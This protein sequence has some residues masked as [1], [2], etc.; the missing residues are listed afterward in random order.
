MRCTC[1]GRPFERLSDKQK[2]RR[3]VE[4]K[5]ALGT[6]CSGITDIGLSLTFIQLETTESHETVSI[7]VQPPQCSTDSNDNDDSNTDNFIPDMT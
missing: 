5:D 6:I 3:K 4:I 7:V 2:Q 1:A